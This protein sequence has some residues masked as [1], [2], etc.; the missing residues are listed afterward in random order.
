VSWPDIVVDRATLLA[1][2]KRMLAGNDEPNRSRCAKATLGKSPPLTSMIA[3]I[4]MCGEAGSECPVGEAPGTRR[5]RHYE[6]IATASQ[7]FLNKPDQVHATNRDL[8][9]SLIA[10]VIPELKDDVAGGNDVRAHLVSSPI[11]KRLLIARGQ[12]QAL[13]SALVHLVFV[14]LAAGVLPVL[15]RKETLTFPAQEARSG[16]SYACNVIKAPYRG[17]YHQFML[18]G[19]RWVQQP[20]VEFIESLRSPEHSYHQLFAATHEAQCAVRRQ[21]IEQQR[22]RPHHTFQA[23]IRDPED[24]RS[25]QPLFI[26]NLQDILIILVAAQ[27]AYLA[28]ISQEVGGNSQSDAIAKLV[29]ANLDTFSLPARMNQEAALKKISH[30]AVRYAN[31]PMEAKPFVHMPTI[32]AVVGDHQNLKLDLTPE[33]AYL[34]SVHQSFCAGVVPHRS[35]DRGGQK[36]VERLLSVAGVPSGRLSGH[37]DYGKIDPLTILGIIAVHIAKDTIFRESPF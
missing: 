10:D 24:F 11:E 15:E 1:C 21:R 29:L 28:H 7:D 5:R 8:F 33:Y 9:C 14:E 36:V 2:G 22:R 26:G 23:I 37:Q 4:S 27:K 35:R 16:D 20:A 3:R 17:A 32:F 31:R 34:K 30:P 12:H 13:R 18:A 25:Y 6:I 19:A